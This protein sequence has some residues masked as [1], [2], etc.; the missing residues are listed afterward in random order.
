MHGCR[1][2]SSS[3]PR[4]RLLL[5]ISG[6][7]GVVVLAVAA[8]VGCGGQLQAPSPA[9]Q[10]SEPSPV[11]QEPQQESPPAALPIPQPVQTLPN[12]MLRSG[13]A[14]S[15]AYLANTVSASAASGATYVRRFVVQL[16]TSLPE[17]VDGAALR[18]YEILDSP[19]GWAGT[20]GIAFELVNEAD[21]ADLVIHLASPQTVDLA[22]AALNTAGLWS[23]RLGPDI[24]LNV[25][26]WF[27]A[28]PTWAD[29]SI[30]DYRS[31]L[32]NHEVGHYIGFGHVG[33]PAVGAPSPVMQQ[34]SIDLNGCLPNAW[35]DVTGERDG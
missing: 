29:Q 8:L 31:Y 24:Y 27:Y 12:G 6:R 18:M 16:E 19:R 13:V 4:V 7:W 33:C 2:W 10:P 34:Q 9:L 3:S 5:V 14:S 30:D 1:G 26:R 11:Q 25:D 21:Q 20:H 32:I 35:P 22:C 17:S 28:T 15:G 23:C